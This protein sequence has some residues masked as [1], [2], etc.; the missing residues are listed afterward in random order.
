MKLNTSTAYGLLAV[1][2]IARNQHK[3]LVPSRTIAN[4][5]NIPFDYFS[6]IMLQLVR[7]N[8]L[9]SRRG[10][11][12]GFSLARSPKKI[13]MLEILEAVEGPLSSDL[14]LSGHTAAEK[15]A[16]KAR[17]TSHKAFTQARNILKAV[18][19]SDLI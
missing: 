10:P 13:T 9:R 16:S 3:G 17:E 11:H 1:G 6:R 5:Y 18:K 4:Q 8:I 15:F 19:L 2:Y 14:H 12:G 7:A